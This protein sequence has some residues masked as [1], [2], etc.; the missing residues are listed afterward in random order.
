VFQSAIA[1][2]AAQSRRNAPQRSAMLGIGGNGGLRRP[3]ISASTFFLGS[4]PHLRVEFE[5]FGHPGGA[6]NRSG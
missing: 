2:H 3:T 1:T 4:F 5:Y 6:R